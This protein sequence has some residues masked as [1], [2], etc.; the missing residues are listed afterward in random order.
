MMQL[1]MTSFWDQNDNY[2]FYLLFDFVGQLFRKAADASRE[3]ES[4]FTNE[5]CRLEMPNCP[6]VF[7]LVKYKFD[8]EKCTLTYWVNSTQCLKVFI[9]YIDQS[10]QNVYIFELVHFIVT[11]AKFISQVN[12]LWPD[13]S[14]AG[15]NCSPNHFR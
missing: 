12:T 13:L 1:F 7:C 14:K 15:E 8:S 6:N 3:I 10:S 4:R 9:L 2:P 11:F 5:K